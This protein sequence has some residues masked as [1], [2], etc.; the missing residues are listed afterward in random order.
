LVPHTQATK[1]ADAQTEAGVA[2]RVELMLGAG[3]GWGGD[4]QKR[5]TEETFRFLD[6]LLKR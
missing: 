1:L 3:H 6:Q 5:T 4:D 2:G